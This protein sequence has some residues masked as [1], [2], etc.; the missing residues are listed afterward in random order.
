MDILPKR[1]QKMC[2]KNF[3]S[4]NMEL[5][6]S[7]TLHY[8]KKHKCISYSPYKNN[9]S[10]TDYSITEN[11]CP[12]CAC[13]I[14]YRG[15]YSHIITEFKK[16]GRKMYYYRCISCKEQDKQLCETT[17]MEK[18]VCDSWKENMRCLIACFGTLDWEIPVDVKMY[19]LMTAKQLKCQH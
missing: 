17:F 4:S 9:S 12:I 15:P 19:I 13:E 2:E 16:D 18:K 8:F 6:L 7:G 10:V 11:Y 5:N 3:K 1:L 14:K